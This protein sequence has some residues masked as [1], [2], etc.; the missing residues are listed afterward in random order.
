MLIESREEGWME[1]GPTS[2]TGLGGREAVR[3]ELAPPP[4]DARDWVAVTESALPVDTAGSWPVLASCGAVV[5]FTGTVR[6]YSEGRP[7]VS[8]LEYEAYEEHAAGAL[9]SLAD[10]ARRRWPDL[11]R[12]VMLHRTGTM[13]PGEASVV[14]SASAPHRGEAFDAVRYLID[15][16]KETVPIWKRETWMGGTD[17]SATA[18]DIEPLPGISRRTQGG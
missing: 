13:A 16:L 10:E 3:A 5:V 14:V 9:A 8:V 11:G 4:G 7:G 17:W 15:T 18:H 1:E 6:D 2:A 12:I